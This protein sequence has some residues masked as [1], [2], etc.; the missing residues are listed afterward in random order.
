MSR[1]FNKKKKVRIL[2]LGTGEN[3][4]TPVTDK[5]SYDKKAFLKYKA[6]FMMNMDTYSA[7]FYLQ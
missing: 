5:Y 7:D 3:P 6:E 1:I 2:S 4:F